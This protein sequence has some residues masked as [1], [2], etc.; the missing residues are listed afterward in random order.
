MLLLRE[1]KGALSSSKIWDKT[2]FEDIHMSYH[3]AR[4]ETQPLDLNSQLKASWGTCLSIINQWAVACVASLLCRKQLGAAGVC[5]DLS[6]IPK[7]CYMR[8]FWKQSLLTSEWI[9]LVE[10]ISAARNRS[11]SSS[12]WRR[13][14]KMTECQPSIA[15]NLS[16]EAGESVTQITIWLIRT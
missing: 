15:Q 5:N 16:Y 8:D 14:D 6:A 7:K 2:Y 12:N 1:E 10:V 13:L 4:V 9:D 3:T 11:S